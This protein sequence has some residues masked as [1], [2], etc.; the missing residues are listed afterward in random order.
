MKH[1]SRH[2][3]HSTTRFHFSRGL[4]AAW[5]LGIG[6]AGSAAAFDV[7]PEARL[8]LD[9][10]H[11]NADAKPLD[12]GW[13]V[14]RATVGLKGK[15]N[16]DWS[17]EAAYELSDD[18]HLRPRDGKFK[19]VTLSYE[20]WNAVSITAGQ[21]KVPFGLEELTSSNDISFIE[22][23]LPVDAFGLSRRLGMGLDHQRAN[24]TASAMVFGSVIEG[25]ERGRGAAVRLTAAPVHS[26]QSVVHLGI[27]AVTEKPDSKVDFDASPESRVADTDLVNTGGI[28]DVSRIHRIGLE[29]AWRNGP[30]SLQ[31]EWMRA[32]VRRN[33][34]HANANLDGWYVAGSWVLTG[35]SRPYKKGRFKGIEPARAAGAWELSARYSRIDLDDGQ[36]RGGRQ[37]NTS[38]GLNYY[39]GKNLRVMLN[40]IQAHSQ[41]RGINDDPR[42]LLLRMQL[43]M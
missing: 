17:F 8:H 37:H 34:G 26:A 33:A 42:I 29:G 30:F 16:A 10:A 1:K 40:Y 2:T 18:G 27:A 20:G 4:L 25:D 13:A 38:V 19:D 5:V 41:R 23:A 3:M 35:E 6:S 14:R 32:Q 12:D 43:T 24:Y 36:V 28:S 15:F 22:R 21:F 7:K 9:Y 31:S 39:L 11:H